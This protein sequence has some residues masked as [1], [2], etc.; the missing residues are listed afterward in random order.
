MAAYPSRHAGV[1]SAI[2][3]SAKLE[4]SKSKRANDPVGGFDLSSH[5]GEGWPPR[6]QTSGVVA[7]RCRCLSHP[8]ERSESIWH[9]LIVVITLPP[10]RRRDCPAGCDRAPTVARLGRLCHWPPDLTA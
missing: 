6:S 8:R 4:L 2:R 9:A 7:L 10:H 1:V 5:I 3:A